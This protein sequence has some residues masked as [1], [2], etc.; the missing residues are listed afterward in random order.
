MKWPVV[1]VLALSLQA[2]NRQ[3][4][5]PVDKVVASAEDIAQAVTKQPEIPLAKGPYA[6]RDTCFNVKG[7]DAFRVK[8]AQVVKDRDVDGMVALAASD[9][10]LDFNGGSGSEELRRRLEDDQW[11]LWEELDE[12]MGLGCATNNQGGITLPWY[13]VQNYGSILPQNGMIVT[14][15]N[16]R[17]MKEPHADAETLRRISWDIV[18]IDHLM[19]DDR[20]QPVTLSDG[21]K[22]YIDSDRLRSLLDYRLVASSRNGKWSITSFTAGD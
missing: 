2:C 10:K 12:L 7:A 15:E 1:I 20:Y 5:A 19:P 14:G 11:N 13:F 16:V 21:E 9:I 4:D 6:P 8:L 18:K 17:V 3:D 22:G